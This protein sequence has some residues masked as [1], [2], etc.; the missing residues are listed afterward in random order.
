MNEVSVY[1][2][3]T[4]DWYGNYRIKDDQRVSNLVH[5]QF[6]KLSN[7]QWRCCVWGN[8]D[9]GMEFDSWL[10]GEAWNKFIQIIGWKYVNKEPLKALGFVSA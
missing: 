1:C 2:E 9:F 4:D 3:T 10:E 7:D 6:M 8:D 5:V